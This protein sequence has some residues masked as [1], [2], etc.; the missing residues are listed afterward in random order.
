MTTTTDLRTAETEDTGERAPGAGPPLGSMLASDPPPEGDGGPASEA[1]PERTEVLDADPARAEFFRLFL[2]DLPIEY[3]YVEHRQ[4][5]FQPGALRDICGPI[6]PVSAP[7]RPDGRGWAMEVEFLDRDGTLRHHVFAQTK[8]QGKG[9]WVTELIDMGFAV[10]ASWTHLTELLRTWSPAP[11]SWSVDHAGW[12]TD[13]SDVTSFVHPN[14]LVDRPSQ[15]EAPRVVHACPA[16]AAPMRGNLEGWQHE[17]APLVLGSPVP[18]F[19]VAAGLAG[20][21]LHGSGIDTMGFNVFGASGIGKSLLLRLALGCGAAPGAL[22]PW[23][24]A[25]TGLHRLSAISQDGLL[26]LDAF[27]RDPD[28]RHLKALQAISDDGSSGRILPG[29]DPDGGEHWR[30]VLLSSSELPLSDAFRRRRKDLPSAFATR[31]ID[32]PGGV[33]PHGVFALLHEAADGRALARRLEDGL[34]RH[35]GHLLPAFLGGIV[36]DLA[37]LRAEI[38]RDLWALTRAIQDRCGV[39]APHSPACHG[40]V[41]ERLALVALAGELA[42]EMALLPWPAGTCREAAILMALRAN[43]PG[44]AG[45]MD[46]THPLDILRGLIDEHANRI[47]DLDAAGPRPEVAEAIGW[48]DDEHIYLKRESLEVDLDDPDLFWNSLA[49]DRILKPGGEAGSRQYKLPA[50]KVPGRPRCYRLDRRRVENGND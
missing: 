18:V 34:G 36:N 22:K 45:A 2:R 47:V 4:V 3:V 46:G 11:H 24:A 21:L 16:P 48:R 5:I 10:H 38:D 26:T 15:V 35:H 1:G 40:P 6:R 31:L 41:A 42:I 30:R 12:F 33:D 27:P 39:E 23:S 28:T 8:L 14:G 37:R 19:A 13:P 43:V 20:P 9:G 7:R 17:I 32:I 29:R 44:A 50:R 25:L 49:N